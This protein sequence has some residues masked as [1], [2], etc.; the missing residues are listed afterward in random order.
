MLCL[1]NAGDSHCQKW[2]SKGTIT[3]SKYRKIEE[4]CLKGNQFLCTYV[5]YV[6]ERMPTIMTHELIAMSEFGCSS[7]NGVHCMIL[8]SIDPIDRGKYLELGCKFKEKRSCQKLN[9]FKRKS[10][11]KVKFNKK[12]F[13]K[14]MKDALNKYLKR[15]RN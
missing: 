14:N 11:K 13:E 1:N 12:T 4:G 3:L 6:Q 2:V 10:G 5:V 8:A 9:E 7:G 15:K